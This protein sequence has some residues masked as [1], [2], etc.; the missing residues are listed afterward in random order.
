[1]LSVLVNHIVYKS[2]IA[3]GEDQTSF[4]VRRVQPV[5]VGFGTE[6]WWG[7]NDKNMLCAVV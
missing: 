1:M 3:F 2:A 5:T 6:Y 7:D 4:D